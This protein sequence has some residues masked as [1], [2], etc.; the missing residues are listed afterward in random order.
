MNLR[1]IRVTTPLGHAFVVRCALGRLA[2]KTNGTARAATSGIPLTPE[3]SA[4]LVC[5]VGLRPNACLVAAGRR[6]Q[7]GMHGEVLAGPASVINRDE[8]ESEEDKGSEE[9][10]SA[11]PPVV[12]PSRTE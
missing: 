12:S 5:T 1:K 9:S 10:F 3:E 6:T 4:P 2:R 11:G 8:S 7:C